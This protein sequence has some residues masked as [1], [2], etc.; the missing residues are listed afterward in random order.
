MAVN[1]LR[2]ASLLFHEHFAD[3][4]TSRLCFTRS[5]AQ[6]TLFVDLARNE[7]VAVRVDDLMIVGS[8]SQLF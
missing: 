2:D 6:P 8:T 3:V 7:F 1:V 5:E 4:L